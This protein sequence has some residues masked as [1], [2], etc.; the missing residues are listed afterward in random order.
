VYGRTTTDGDVHVGSSGS[1]LPTNGG[2]DYGFYSAYNAF[3]DNDGFWKHSRQTTVDAYMFKGGH[4]LGGFSWNFS[5]NVGS[6]NI[7][8]SEWMILNQ[9][10]LQLNQGGFIINGRSNSDIVLA[11]GGYRPVDDF[12]LASSVVTYTSSLGIS[13][14][15]NDFRPT[16]GTAVNTIAQ[17]NDSRF[18][19]HANMSVLDGITSTLV[20]NW[21]NAETKSHTHSNLSILNGTQESF[22]TVLKNKLDGLSNYTLPTASATVLGG[23]KLFSDTVQTVASNAVTTTASRTYGV[24]VNS[25][26]QMV[27]NV[28]WT[29]TV[30]THPTGA[31]NNHIPTGGS[32]G[33]VLRWSAS[34]VAV[35]GNETPSNTYTNGTGLNLSGNSFS[36]KY[37][38]S[39]GTSAEGNHTHNWTDI[40]NKPTSFTPTSHSH[41]ISEVTGLS[42]ELA[43]KSEKNTDE[44]WWSIKRLTHPTPIIVKQPGSKSW[45]LHKPTFNYLIFAPSATV[46]NEDWDWSKQIALQDDGRMKCNGYEVAGYDDNY[47]NT[48]GG[49]QAHKKDLLWSRKYSFRADGAVHVIEPKGEVTT[50]VVTDGSDINTKIQL[51]LTATNGQ[52]VVLINKSSDYVIVTDPINNVNQN[53]YN[54]SGNYGMSASQACMELTFVVDTANAEGVL[55]GSGH[56]YGRYGDEFVII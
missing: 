47:V 50:I 49:N 18:H 8:W 42:T 16:Y 52:K 39:A 9:T 37:G 13:K 36:V 3:R 28:P 53:F 43:K 7:S 35:W 14:V 55:T 40:G 46:N 10:G 30:Y 32:S 24:Q 45:V 6:G 56:W 19:T 17:G 26:G 1:S 12:A 25:T 21:N 2:Q 29:D 31:G 33:Q 48:S 22:T 38:T 5:S 54:N 15:G 23:V 20:T 27:V 11:G 41:A 34:G 51:P 4:H 44:E